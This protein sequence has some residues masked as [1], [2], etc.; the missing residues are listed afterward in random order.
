MLKDYQIIVW[1]S[2]EDACYVASIPDFKGCMA[3]GDTPE[4]AITSICIAGELWLESA[5]VHGTPIP[6]PTNVCYTQ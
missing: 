3:D 2:K 6:L 4:E 5:K 1:Y